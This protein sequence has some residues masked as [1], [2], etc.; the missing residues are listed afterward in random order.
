MNAVQVT[1]AVLGLS[2]VVMVIL[3][4]TTESTLGFAFGGA[5][6]AAGIYV[7]VTFRGRDG[8]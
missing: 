2:G 1:G 4:M 5:C 7:V 8:H 6:V 3:A